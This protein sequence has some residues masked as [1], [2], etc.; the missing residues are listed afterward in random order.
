MFVNRFRHI[1]IEDNYRPGMG[2]CYSIKAAQMGGGFRADHKEFISVPRNLFDWERL[3]VFL[4]HLEEV[5]PITQPELTRWGVP[6]TADRFPTR[7]PLFRASEHGQVPNEFLVDAER[8]TWMCFCRLR[9][10]TAAS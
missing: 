2:D 9:R 10:L 1:L 7:A 4:E 6:W 5:P 8:F 3:S